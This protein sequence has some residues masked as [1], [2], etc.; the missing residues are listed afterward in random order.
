MGR[1]LFRLPDIGEGVA[2]AEIVTWH[3][4]RGD[5]VAEDQSLVDVMTDK[6]TVEMT[7]PVDGVVAA[8]HGEAG[9]MMPVGSV[10]VELETEG[11]E[12][13]GAGAGEGEEAARDEAP[14]IKDAAPAAPPPAQ[15][16]ASGPD[17]PTP[18]AALEPARREGPREQQGKGRDATSP[19]VYPPLA[20]PSTRRRALELGVP[21]EQVHGSGSGGRILRDDLDRY[22]AEA[23]EGA[24]GSIDAAYRRR[25]GVEDIP[26]TGLRRRIAERMEQAWRHIPHI[27]Y[28]EEVDVTELEALRHALNADRGADQPRLTLL[29]FFLRALVRVLPDFPR[30]NAHYD[31]EA[32]VLRAHQAV[33]VGI[34]TQTPGGLMVPVLRHAE[35]RSVRALGQEVARLA[36]SARDGK[37]RREELSGST[38][39]LTSLGALGGIAATPI[40]NPPEVA[41]LC[42][43]RIVE[44]PV[45]DGAFLSRRR[46]MNLSSSFD[47]RII[48]GHDAALFIQQIKRMLEH[49]A[50]IFM[51]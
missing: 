26:V 30:M 18:A 31:D 32:G 20:S 13:E 5:R 2:E 41:I 22:L 19:P 4:Q 34:A 10:L 28:V 11:G 6:A 39:T 21:L 49:P 44:R 15:G 29:P 35:T 17:A 25:E 12:D 46:M 47:H 37:A 50:L 3:V 48:D 43:N 1:Y 40:L 23:G 14:D 36:A 42:P 8:L 24:S 7:S 9:V 33:H 45:A 27:S 38:I 16:D 51:D